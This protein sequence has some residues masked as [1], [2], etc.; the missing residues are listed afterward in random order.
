MIPSHFCGKEELP[1][2][3]PDF[4]AY[5]LV[6]RQELSRILETVHRGRQECLAAWKVRLSTFRMTAREK[7]AAQGLFQYLLDHFHDSANFSGFKEQFFQRTAEYRSILG[8]QHTVAVIGLFEEIIL[9]LLLERQG[10]PDVHTSYRWLHSLTLSLLCSI[11]REHSEGRRKERNGPKLPLP[12]S[13]E[14]S[15]RLKRMEAITRLDEW[16]LTSRTLEEALSRSVRFITEATGFR[17]GALFWYSSLSRTV[18][19]IYAHEVDLGEIRR[20]RDVEGNI[21]A[22]ARV[23]KETKPLYLR[24]ARLYFPA[25]YVEKFGLTSL[26]TATLY[27][28]QRQPVAFLLL[29]QEGRPFEPDPDTEHLLTDLISRVSLTLR[30]RLFENAFTHVDAAPPLTPREREILQM[31]A[32]GH[33]TREIGQALHLSEHTAAEYAHS[34]L[35]KLKAKNRPEAVAVGLRKSWIR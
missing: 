34:V 1:I 11:T 17:R 4:P 19:G 29:D 31:I 30:F 15:P 23:M 14:R 16:L 26:Q 32:D 3:P 33:S 27:G 13:D 18:E 20:I 21:P 22:I 35:R 28:P 5:P 12:G 9:V 10:R 8:L 7:Q 25:H 2:R 6:S 24:E